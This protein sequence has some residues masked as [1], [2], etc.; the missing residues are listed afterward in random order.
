[1]VI[2][3]QIPIQALTSTI[4]T[5]DQY[6][7]EVYLEFSTPSGAGLEVVTSVVGAAET[8]RCER[9]T[10][11]YGSTID[12]RTYS[13][14]HETN[15]AEPG[16]TEGYFIIRGSTKPDGTGASLSV[17]WAQKVSD[18]GTSTVLR[19]SYMRIWKV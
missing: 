7:W 5:T 14:F 12:V 19:G 9:W 6:Q 2:H 18:A 3:H 10:L 8:F 15:Y 16:I 11:H 4:P 13:L 1:M 17:Y